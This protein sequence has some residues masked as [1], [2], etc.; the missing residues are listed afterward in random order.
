M[1]PG[2]VIDCVIVGCGPNAGSI[3]VLVGPGAESWTAEAGARG[4]ATP[5]S[6]WRFDDLDQVNLCK[7]SGFLPS[8][9]SAIGRSQG[10]A[11]DGWC[12]RTA[13]L[14]LL[15][16]LERAVCQQKCGKDLEA[17]RLDRVLARLASPIRIGTRQDSSALVV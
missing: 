13:E 17:I 1:L 4:M 7:M 9:E 16:E 3:R 5:G 6:T 10:L 2:S 12:G 15:V 11:T 8:S 14:T